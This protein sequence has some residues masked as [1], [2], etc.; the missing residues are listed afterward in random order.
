MAKTIASFLITPDGTKLQ[1]YHVH[2]YKTHTDANGEEYMLDG[3][4]EYTRRSVNKEPAAYHCI[5]MDDP[6]HLRREHFAWGT[7]GKQGNEP[8]TW[9]HLKDMDTDHIEAILATCSP[10]EYLVHLFNDELQW[11]KNHEILDTLVQLSQEQGD[12]S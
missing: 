4:C 10:P 9:K 6:H 1:S 3:G 7:Y 11:R 8:L 2:D 12:Y 5:T